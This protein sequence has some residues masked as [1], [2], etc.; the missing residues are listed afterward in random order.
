M[1]DDDGETLEEIYEETA[2]LNDRFSY[3]LTVYCSSYSCERD[4][5]V[6]AKGSILLVRSEITGNQIFGSSTLV[7]EINSSLTRF[8]IMM[9][10]ADRRYRPKRKTMNY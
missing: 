6:I 8:I 4:S 10:L 3:C 2:Y 9:R 7:C 5:T 1:D